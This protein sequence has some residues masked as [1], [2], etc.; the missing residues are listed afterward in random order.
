MPCG[1]SDEI[2]LNKMLNEIYKGNACALIVE[3]SNLHYLR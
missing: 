2:P 3:L 1:T